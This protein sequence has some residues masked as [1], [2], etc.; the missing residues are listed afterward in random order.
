M[1]I[2]LTPDHE[3]LIRSLLEGG[4][5]TTEAQVLGEALRLLQEREEQA[6]LDELRREIA[7]GIERAD[8][9]DTA[10]FDTWATLRRVRSRETAGGEGT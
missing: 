8:R 1:T 2:H 5:F 3:E 9:G 6:R 7:V 4:R 10:P